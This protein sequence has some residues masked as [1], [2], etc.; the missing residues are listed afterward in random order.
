M[1]P[2]PHVLLASAALAW[3]ALSM[4]GPSPRADVTGWRGGAA[5]A[6]TAPLAAGTVEGTV[7]LTAAT[8]PEPPMLGPYSRRRYR[9]PSRS[10]SAAPSPE[11]VVVFV[12]VDDAVPAPADTAARIVQR[13]RTIVPHVTAIQVGTTVSFPNLDDVYHNLFSL[14]GPH[15]FNLGRYP[16]GEAR[17]QVFRQPGVIRMFCDIHSEMTGVIRVVDSPHFTRPD[18]EGAFRIAGVPAGTHRV[19]AWHET[20]G[21]DTVEVEVPGGGVAHVELRVA[22]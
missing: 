10:P 16:P 9:P 15:P 13:N 12:V 1:D 18:G 7:R 4:C 20:A 8:A 5:A 3:A 6:S 17:T 19:V 22:E 14:S 11:D 2:H 21:A